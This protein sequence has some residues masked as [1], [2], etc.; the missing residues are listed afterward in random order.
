MAWALRLH[1]Q[2]GVSPSVKPDFGH[3][4]I[5]QVRARTELPDKRHQSVLIAGQ[6]QAQHSPGYFR[7]PPSP[8]KPPSSA[9]WAYGRGGRCRDN[10][11]TSHPVSPRSAT[12][13]WLL[14]DP[15][16]AGRLSQRRHR[17]G[18]PRGSGD[19]LIGSIE[20]NYRR[21]PPLPP[22]SRC[23]CLPRRTYRC[24][25]Q[26]Q[27][28]SRRTS[29][30]SWIQMRHWAFSTEPSGMTAEA[31]IRFIPTWKPRRTALTALP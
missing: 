24:E 9:G 13:V 16:A 12:S 11:G 20:L 7:M 19:R 21:P 23:V 3:H 22:R 14:R 27:R 25:P 1:E 18:A 17:S 4:C 10:R 15:L 29:G 30:S 28:H 5:V 2:Y 8:I 31:W 26:R 6:V